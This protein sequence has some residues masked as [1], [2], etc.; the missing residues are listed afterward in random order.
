MASDVDGA[1]ELIRVLE[2]APSRARGALGIALYAEAQRVMKASKMIVPVDTGVLRRSATVK[3]P[4]LVGNRLISVTLGYGGAAQAYAVIQHED[5]SLSHPPKV[6]RRK[7]TSTGKRKR[8]PRAGQAKYLERPILETAP[9]IYGTLARSCDR[10][11]RSA[12]L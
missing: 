10:M 7:Y 1:N 8:T 9:M 11:F 4:V 6:R 5:L 12:G 3:K 2:R